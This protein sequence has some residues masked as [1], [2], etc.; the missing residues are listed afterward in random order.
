MSIPDATEVVEI[1][2][3]HL[4]TIPAASEIELAFFGG[5]FTAIPEEQQ[6]YY[7]QLVQPYLA[8]GRIQGV[9]ISTR[10]DCIDVKNL[11]MLQS[12]GVKTIELGVQSL[13]DEVL[14]LSARRYQAEAV[15]KSAALIR[16]MGF[17]LGIQLMVG[18]P[19]DNYERDMETVKA[20][21]RIKPQMVRIYP[22]LV[23]SG[24]K[25]EQMWMEGKYYP[26]SLE[27]AIQICQDM[28]LA[29]S[30]AGIPVIRMGLYPG[31]ELRSAGVVKAG[32]FHPAFRELVEQAIF[33]EQ[34][35]QIIKS[36]LLQ[37]PKQKKLCLFVHDRDQSK[38][39]GKNRVNL[40][41][42]CDQFALQEITLKTSPEAKRDWIGVNHVDSPG[43]AFGLEREDYIKIREF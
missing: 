17:D 10:P 35:A 42:L 20:S 41:D 40:H 30:A 2:T 39:L 33:R 34:A 43:N 27:A 19:G 8:S 32:P 14:Q 23:I 18:L 15:Y 24:T 21:I 13:H 26:L 31:E 29:F 5:N 4:Q 6:K 9:R 3:G 36:Y 11:Q 7:L 22:T 25:L 38:M 1:M 28:L 12:Y 37:N 16:E